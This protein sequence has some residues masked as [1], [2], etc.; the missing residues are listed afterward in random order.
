MSFYKES[1]RLAGISFLRYS[2]ICARATRQ[3]LKEPLRS[4]QILKTDLF[5]YSWMRYNKKNEMSIGLLSIC[6]SSVSELI[7]KSQPLIDVEVKTNYEDEERKQLEQYVSDNKH[8]LE[9]TDAKDAKPK[10]WNEQP[11]DDW[12]FSIEMIWNVRCE[13]SLHSVIGCINNK[14]FHGFLINGICNCCRASFEHDHHSNDM[15]YSIHSCSLEFIHHSCP[16][17][18][19]SVNFRSLHINCVFAIA[20]LN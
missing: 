14:D 1:Y 17:M 7:A 8:I 6:L 2:N 13:Y 12:E 19:L 16:L 10:M 5:R 20:L 15:M 9:P 18:V 4:D 3:S 11:A